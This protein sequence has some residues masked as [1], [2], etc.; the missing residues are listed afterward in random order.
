[1]EKGNCHMTTV[2]LGLPNQ[3]FTTRVTTLVW[4]KTKM[5]VLLCNLV[6][7]CVDYRTQ[8]HRSKFEFAHC[9]PC[10][11][12]RVFSSLPAALALHGGNIKVT[13]GL[14]TKRSSRS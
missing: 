11:F 13:V 2:A 10:A 1:M 5:L 12:I 8:I 9:V 7:D 6:P 3:I 4:N 14:N